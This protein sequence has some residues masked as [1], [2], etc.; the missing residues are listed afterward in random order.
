MAKKLGDDLQQSFVVENKGGAGG[1]LG[2]DAALKSAP[3]GYTFAVTAQGPLAGMP[4]LSKLPYA[5]GD[6][7]HVSL[8]A[9][10]PA[11]IV[12]GKNVAANNL[13]E[14]AST[15]LPYSEVRL[16]TVSP[17]RTI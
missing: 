8:V 16:P 15:L 7:Q 12:A 11:V 10:G 2:V 14:S 3:D 17:A 5:L 13:P 4:N 9:R 6:V 1:T